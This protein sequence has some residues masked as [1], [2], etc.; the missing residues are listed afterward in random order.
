M[1]VLIATPL[2]DNYLPAQYFNAYLASIP[3]M[4]EAGLTFHLMTETR[5]WISMCRNRCAIKAMELGCDKL[6]FIDSDIIWKPEDLMKLIM[7]KREII[8]GVYPFRYYPLKLNMRSLESQGESMSADEYIKNFS[9]E[10]GEC[11]VE[12]LPTGFLA[13]STSVFRK[14]EPVAQ[15]Y[16]HKDPMMPHEEWEK[17]YFPMYIDPETKYAETE[18]FGFCAMAKK[19]GYKIYWKTD[20]MVDHIGHHIYSLKQPRNI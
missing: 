20:V 17:N 1:K 5:N 8:G 11:E 10:N 9:D 2:F 14:L 12:R 3:V 4:L 18:D 7:S 15:D 6:V 16:R 19:A 13:I